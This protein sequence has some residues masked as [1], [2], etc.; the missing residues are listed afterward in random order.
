MNQTTGTTMAATDRVA[1]VRAFNRFYTSVIGVVS[2]AMLRTPYTLTEAR[3]I[4]EVGQRPATEVVQ[5]RRALDLDPGYL[6]RLLTRFEADGLIVR[7]RSAEDARRQVIALTDAGRRAWRDL[8]ERSVTQVTA[9]LDRLDEDGQR[10]LLDAMTDIQELLADTPRD[11]QVV[12][13]PPGPG[14]FG[15][16]VQRH[17][18]L[19]HREYGWDQTMEAMIARI[20]ADHAAGRDPRREATWIADLAG[21][22]VGSVMCNREDDRTARLRVLLVEPSARGMGVGGRLVD[23]CVRFAR[24]VGYQRMV[25]LTYQTL[26]DARRIYQR[27]G[28][29]IA[30][31]RATRAYGQDLIE[32]TWALDLTATPAGRPARSARP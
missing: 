23:E 13:R 16:I 9:L 17:G 29:H 6:S 31:Q 21:E 24:Q 5:V 8:D 4:F 30:D 15:W 32:Q 27:A 20:V 14:D 26:A 25:L 12:L 1:E 3:V 18:A 10:R 28:F 11:R 22:P 7:T 19:Y 2:E